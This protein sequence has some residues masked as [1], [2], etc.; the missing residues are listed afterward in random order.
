MTLVHSAGVVGNPWSVGVVPYLG[1]LGEVD[2]GPRLV[3][4][5]LG[6]VRADVVVVDVA[7]DDC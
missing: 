5:L 7:V 6:A 2:V 1:Y 4:L 3:L